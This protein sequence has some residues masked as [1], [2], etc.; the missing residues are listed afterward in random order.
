MEVTILQLF[1]CYFIT[2]EGFRKL[3]LDVK[4]SNS[5]NFMLVCVGVSAENV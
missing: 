5:A 2:L 4:N 1:Q 3:F